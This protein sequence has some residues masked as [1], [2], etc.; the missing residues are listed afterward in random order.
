MLLELLAPQRCA[1]CEERTRLLFCPACAPSVERALDPKRAVFDYG[2]AIEVAIQRYKFHARPDLAPRLAAPLAEGAR[3]LGP[4]D[5]VVPVPLHPRR[6]V[7][8]GF[9]QAALLAAPV[10][11]AIGAGYDPR[12]LR[13]VRNTPKQSKLPRNER[14]SNV[15]GAFRCVRPVRGRKVLLID[16]VATTG[17]TLAACEETLIEAGAAAVLPFVLALRDDLGKRPKER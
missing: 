13:R 16:D 17:A 8:R 4:F 6:L 12:S 14:L 1:A 3:A 11:R 9:D 7:E 2:G 15:R 10:A 5:V